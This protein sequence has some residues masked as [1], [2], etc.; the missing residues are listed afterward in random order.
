MEKETALWHKVSDDEKKEI[1]EQA[2]EIMDN[3]HRA[4]DKVENETVEVKVERDECERK[5]TKANI[6]S[7]EFRK[8]MFKNAGKIKDDCIEAERGK[9][10]E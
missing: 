5:E 8:A 4:L 9:W 6:A 7:E 3:F 1:L 10:V 2:K